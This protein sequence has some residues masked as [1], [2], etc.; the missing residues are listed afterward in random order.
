MEI[1]PEPKNIDDSLL[2]LLKTLMGEDG[3]TFLNLDN[4]I[5]AV[6]QGHPLWQAP[7]AI[8]LRA[9]PFLYHRETDSQDTAV[10]VWAL[11]VLGLAS[12]IY[13]RS[14]DMTV[15]DL[16]GSA[17]EPLEARYNSLSAEVSGYALTDEQAHMLFQT[18]F[19]LG[20]LLLIEG[21]E[22]RARG[23]L[24]EMAATKTTKRGPTW[25]SEGLGQSD[26]GDTKALAAIILQDFYAKR[27][28]YEMALYLLTEA[29]A[30]NPPGP[31]SYSEHLLAVVH[32]LLAPAPGSDHPDGRWP[33]TRDSRRPRHR[34]LLRPRQ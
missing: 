28:N 20:V 3:L 29:V 31:F 25:S 33:R 16:V 13:V 17:L 8:G 30:S 4:A 23:I 5:T 22:E 18:R 15:S 10:P 6:K 12:Q 9:L 21:D 11:L 24:C 1:A 26:V 32:G 7:F 14:K 34:R 27:Q 19:A 2:E